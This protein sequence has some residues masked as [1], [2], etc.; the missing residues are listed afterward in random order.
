MNASK[1]SEIQSFKDGIKSELMEQDRAEASKQLFDVKRENVGLQLEA[2]YRQRLM[3]VYSEVKK[4]LDYQVALTD[5]RILIL[6]LSILYYPS[7]NCD[8]IYVGGEEYSA[9]THGQ[10]D[11]R[12]SKEIN[13][14]RIR[15][16]KLEKMYF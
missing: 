13:Y 16:R 10:L 15:S 11:S 4:R 3:Q 14:S 12:T 7:I 2:E 1:N 6:K 5:V 9:K 8:C